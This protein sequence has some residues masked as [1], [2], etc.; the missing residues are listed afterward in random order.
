ME[1]PGELHFRECHVRRVQEL[2][3]PDKE[4]HLVHC[5]RF[6]SFVDSRGI[7]KIDRVYFTDEAW[8]HLSGYAYGQNPRI[9]SFEHLRV[10]HEKR[11]F[12]QQIDHVVGYH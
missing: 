8:F 7:A 4:K 9:W 3:T 11:L 5:T 12:F 2:M 1:V 6:R 10:L